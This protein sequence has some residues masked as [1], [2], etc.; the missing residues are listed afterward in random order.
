MKENHKIETGVPIRPCR[1]MAS[2][3][4]ALA[5]GNLHGPALW[6]ARLHVSSCKQCTAAL[7]AFTNLRAQL[8]AL[9]QSTHYGFHDTLSED[10]REELKSALDKIDSK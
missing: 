4:S 10:R 8:K 5:D 6:Y 1:H 2:W 7:E 9:G 3:V